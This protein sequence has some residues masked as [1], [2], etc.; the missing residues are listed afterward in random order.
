MPI[1]T[2][3]DIGSVCLV[4]PAGVHRH[5]FDQMRGCNLLSKISNFTLLDN[6]EEVAEL[7]YA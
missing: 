3:Q 4:T 2:S 1:P 5:G 6:C 7:A